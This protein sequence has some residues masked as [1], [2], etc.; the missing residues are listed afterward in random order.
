M[1]PERRKQ[2]EERRAAAKA[3]PRREIEGTIIPRLMERGVPLEPRFDGIWTPAYIRVT[4]NKLWWPDSPPPV[5]MEW[6][7]TT[8]RDDPDGSKQFV[9]R[10]QVIAGMLERAT[11]PD[12][13]VR[14]S[15]DTGFETDL[16]IKASDALANLD[17]LLDFGW[18]IW[19]TSRAENWL[20]E[21]NRDDTA[22]LATPPQVTAMEKTR[23]EAKIRQWT[24]PLAGEL[25]KHGVPFTI[26]RDNDPAKPDA[27]LLGRNWD[28]GKMP[29]SLKK[30]VEPGNADELRDIIVQFLAPRIGEHG[31]VVLT[32]GIML[33]D[34]LEGAPFVV[35]PL[36]AMAAHF[37]AVITMAL[38]E[39]DRPPLPPLQICTFKILDP[40]GEW[41]MYIRLDH[42]Y[43]R[44][45]AIG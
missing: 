39:I 27:L 2:L 20:I 30:I 15:Y 13:Q 42:P 4:G 34:E 18:T 24:E 22:R 12:T 3:N 32:L 1:D 25:E 44:A 19:I 45:F 8:E 10:Q 33:R 31:Q 29:K 17:V 6:C 41:Q 40:E 37:D 23:D 21:L 7:G 16:V 9:L 43:W 11:G 26:I 5:E 38:R 35:L 14:F 36:S 28:W